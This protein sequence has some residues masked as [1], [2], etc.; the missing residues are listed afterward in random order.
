MNKQS[1]M[2]V[3]V[4]TLACTPAWARMTAAECNRD[5][6]SATGVERQDRINDCIWPIH[7]S[8]REPGAYFVRSVTFTTD[9]AGGVKPIVSIVNP[10]KESAIKYLRLTLVAPNRV[11]DQVGNLAHVRMTGPLTNA[12]VVHEASWSSIA[13]DSTVSGIRIFY[14]SVEF[15]N[16]ERTICSRSEI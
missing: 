5:A 12:Q 8:L 4:A 11:G 9:A 6:G 15:M 3:A 16:G 7:K 14:L 1:V 2:A 13:Y 10:N